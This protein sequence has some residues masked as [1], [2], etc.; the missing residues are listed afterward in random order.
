MTRIFVYDLDGSRLETLE[1]PAV[2]DHLASLG[3][4]YE[5]WAL[6][7]VPSPEEVLAVYAPEVEA[8][9]ARYGYQSVDVVRMTPDHPQREA[10]RAR[11]R[12][13]HTHS[14]DETR[15]FVEGSGVF[16]L[17]LDDRVHAVLCEAGDLL[18]VPAHTR[19]WFD[20][21][22]SPSFCA[23]RLFCRP[24][25]WVASFTGDPIAARVAD[26]DVLASP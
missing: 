22:R 9:C 13:E 16:Y 6:R 12:D 2:A 11:F 26:F 23:V 5:R 15:F 3:V 4:G 24:D 17:R 21:G 10:A 18:R 20:M 8:L 19:H 25:G 7:P 14:D 1:G